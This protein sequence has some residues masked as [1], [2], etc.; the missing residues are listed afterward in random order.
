[1]NL[2]AENKIERDKIIRGS[3]RSGGVIGDGLS[4]LMEED[5]TTRLF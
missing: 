3:E 2:A 4:G 5:K 1:M